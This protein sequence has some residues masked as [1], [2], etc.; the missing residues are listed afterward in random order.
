MPVACGPVS[1]VACLMRLQ[2]CLY[3]SVSTCTSLPTT[4]EL[5]TQKQLKAATEA[6]DLK[7]VAS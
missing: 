3:V 2:V 4:S 7:E 5:H 6:G 1:C